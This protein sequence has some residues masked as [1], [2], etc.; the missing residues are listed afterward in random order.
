MAVLIVNR[1]KG[2]IAKYVQ[3]L[4]ANVIM[5]LLKTFD[6]E[7]IESWV[8]DSWW[9]TLKSISAEPPFYLP[10]AGLSGYA[11]KIITEKDIIPDFINLRIWF[12]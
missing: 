5:K 3:I 7:I 2:V 9:N 4:N 11:L 10:L 8:D 1:Q 12:Y 6:N